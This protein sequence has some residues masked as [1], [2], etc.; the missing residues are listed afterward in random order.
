M[1]G[2]LDAGSTLFGTEVRTEVLLA[3]R[4]LEETWASELARALGVRLFTV[5]S[6]LRSLEREG[7]IT[8]R[9]VGAHAWCR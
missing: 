5:Q 1:S 7:V 3:I 9:T 2:G 4:L 8:A 6:V